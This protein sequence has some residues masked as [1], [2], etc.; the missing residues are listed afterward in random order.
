MNFK[1][2]NIKKMLRNEYL[3]EEEKA[4]LEFMG[5]LK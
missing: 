2:F 5:K 4:T 3:L 1:T